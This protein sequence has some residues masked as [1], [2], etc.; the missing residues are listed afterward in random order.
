MAGAC[1]VLGFVLRLSSE[2]SNNRDPSDCRAGDLWRLPL[3]RNGVTIMIAVKPANVVP[4]AAF[5]F[6]R[7]FYLRG[8]CAEPSVTRRHIYRG[9]HSFFV[10]DSRWALRCC[11][12]SR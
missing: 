10:L 6:A 11:G 4:D 8:R 7:L 2:S 1:F 3:I 5:G 12:C 9:N